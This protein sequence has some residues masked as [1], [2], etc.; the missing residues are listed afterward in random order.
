MVTKDGVLHL[1]MILQCSMEQSG[2]CTP[3][4]Y[5]AA[6][7]KLMSGFLGMPEDYPDNFRE[8]LRAKDAVGVDHYVSILTKAINDEYFPHVVV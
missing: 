7:E 5:T 1:V 2:A 8:M 3:S 4:E 6:C